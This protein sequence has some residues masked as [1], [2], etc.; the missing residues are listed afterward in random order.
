ML[1]GGVK[2][3]MFRMPSQKQST[4]NRGQRPPQK[5]KIPLRRRDIQTQSKGNTVAT[6]EDPTFKSDP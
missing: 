3:V 4:S 1:R 6:T 5:P 2:M